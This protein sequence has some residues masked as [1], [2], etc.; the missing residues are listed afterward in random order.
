MSVKEEPEFPD[1]EEFETV[2]NLV[3]I[4]YNKDEDSVEVENPHDLPYHEVLGL[5]HVALETWIEGPGWKAW[6][7]DDEDDD[8]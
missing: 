1:L 2:N 6:G 3:V 5:L 8:E 4:V 7:E